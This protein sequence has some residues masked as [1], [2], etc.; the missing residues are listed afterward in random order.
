MAVNVYAPLAMAEAFQD[1][2]AA[3][4]QKKIVSMTSRSGIIS[5]PG[6]RGPAFYRASKIGLNMVTRVMADDLREK[7]IVVAAISPPPTDTDMLRALIGADGASR[8]AKPADVIA[9]LITVIEGLTLTNS[10]ISPIF[11]PPSPTS[12][13]TPPAFLA[14]SNTAGRSVTARYT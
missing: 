9:R 11:T 5:Q 13:E 12:V 3:S 6:Y 10:A 14:R 4:T 2:V 7:G 8:Q 1:S